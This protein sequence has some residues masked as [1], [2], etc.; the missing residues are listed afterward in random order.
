VDIARIQAAAQVLDAVS[1]ILIVPE[2]LRAETLEPARQKLLDR[3]T[4]A[5]FKIAGEDN[6]LF[7]FILFAVSAFSFVLGYALHKIFDII[8]PGL[9][10]GY[11][12]MTASG[13]GMIFTWII[14]YLYMIGQSIYRRIF[15]VVGA[16][17]FFMTRAAVCYAHLVF[18]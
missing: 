17:L 11:L 13:F 9:F 18:N 6:P 2:F 7:A 5:M 16:T 10:F 14:I 15:F 1:F 3:T 4:K 12:L 8:E